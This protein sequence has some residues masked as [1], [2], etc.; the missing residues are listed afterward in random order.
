MPLRLHE[1]THDPKG[2]IQLALGVGCYAWDDCVVR[3]LARSYAVWMRRVQAEIV[4][5]VLQREATALWN[6]TCKRPAMAE[7]D[8]SSDTNRARSTCLMKERALPFSGKKLL[9]LVTAASRTWGIADSAAHF[10]S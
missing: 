2:G 4:T 8:S 7:N 5:P 3:T 10:C 9:T 1:V 6:D